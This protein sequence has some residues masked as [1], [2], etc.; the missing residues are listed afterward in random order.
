MVG[1]TLLLSGFGFGILALGGALRSREA[2]VNIRKPHVS[3]T[4]VPIT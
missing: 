3:R 1:F 2:M 4:P